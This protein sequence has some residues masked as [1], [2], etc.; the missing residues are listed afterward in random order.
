MKGKRRGEERRC[1]G[2][3]E[4]RCVKMKA[5]VLIFGGR[6]VRAWPRF[7]CRTSHIL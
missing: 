1:V 7:M 6:L 5:S 3:E 2:Q 4:R